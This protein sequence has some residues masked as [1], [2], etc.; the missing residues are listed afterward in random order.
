M[1]KNKL[2]KVWLLTT[3]LSLSTFATLAEE[4]GNK[5]RDYAQRKSVT[6][7]KAE[8]LLIGEDKIN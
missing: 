7:L 3:V 5:D 2:L 4:E 6:Y 1:N 8:H